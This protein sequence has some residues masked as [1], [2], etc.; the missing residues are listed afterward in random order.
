MHLLRSI[1]P[2]EDFSKSEK[3]LSPPKA[4]EAKR[5]EEA[6][7]EKVQTQERLEN[8]EMGHVE[9]ISKHEHSLEQ[10]R[11]MLQEVRLR[12]ATV[13]DWVSALRALVADPWEPGG[14]EVQ[15]LPPPLH[16]PVIVEE[17]VGPEET[18]LD[19]EV[20]PTET[21]IRADEDDEVGSI[22]EWHTGQRNDKK[23]SAG[24]EKEAW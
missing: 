1:L 4:E 19:N 10:Q 7:W 18:Q 6:L 22:S 3:V 16:P 5:R 9:Q 20:Q 24:E 2:L 23:C 14:N 17:I 8:Q 21:P 13:R 11:R 15:P 12:L